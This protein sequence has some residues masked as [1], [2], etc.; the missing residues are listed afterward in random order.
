[1]IMNGH[2]MSHS[3]HTA[4]SPLTGSLDWLHTLHERFETRCGAP[5]SE[6][7]IA[8]PDLIQPDSPHL[9]Q[10]LALVGET[11]ATSDRQIGVSFFMNSYAW[12]IAAASLGCYIASSRVPDLSPS[13]MWLR[14][15]A[16][17][18][19]TG[20]SFTRGRFWALPDDAAAGHPDAAI[21]QNRV[22]LRDTLRGQIEVHMQH[23]IPIL[24]PKSSFGTRALWVTVADRCAGF[25]FWLHQQ[26]PDVL[27]RDR[28]VQEVEGLIRAPA[29]P[30]NNC[31]TGIQTQPERAEHELT[32]QRGACCL[33]YKRPDGKYC[34]SC[35]IC[36]G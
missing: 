23:M 19:A 35:P 7:W 1:M 26:R 13:N 3:D 15:E 34:T 24:R 33:N 11:Y 22:A 28:L 2:T 18:R 32:F 21:V 10:L 16:N 36:A 20:I 29:S 12:L 5:P 6:D 9:S 31:L 4:A 25:L 30:F 17:G 27:G 8:V 14:F